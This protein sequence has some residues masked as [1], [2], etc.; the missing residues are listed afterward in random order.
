MPYASAVQFTQAIETEETLRRRKFTRDEYYRMADAGFFGVGSHV[1]LIR[2]EIFEKLSPQA[3]PHIASIALST[4]ALFR[5]APLGYYVVGQVPLPLPDGSEPEPDILVIK[6]SPRDY[7]ETSPA[8]ENVGLVV[9]ISDTTLGYDRKRKAPLYASA[10]IS[11]YW[12]VN[13]VDR[14]LEVY[15]DPSLD[16]GYRTTTI[17]TATEVVTPVCATAAVVAVADLLP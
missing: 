3:A 10:G 2:G 12:I 7:T 4:A 5:A 16:S 9:E 13:L 1:E 15:R 8:M 6:G 11:E 14:R 17:Y